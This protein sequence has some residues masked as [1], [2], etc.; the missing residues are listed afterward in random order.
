MCFVSG[1]IF[2][3]M[4]HLYQRQTF[5]GLE[6]LHLLFSCGG[7]IPGSYSRSKVLVHI[8]N[9]VAY[10]FER[11]VLEEQQSQMTCIKWISY[12]FYRASFCPCKSSLSARAALSCHQCLY[13]RMMPFIY[14]SYESRNTLRSYIPGLTVRGRGLR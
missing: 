12:L 3:S 7:P 2:R 1:S 9:T 13:C 10:G 4:A 8:E 5:G 6:A 11:E 14:A